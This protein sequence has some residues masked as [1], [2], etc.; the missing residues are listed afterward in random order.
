MKFKISC[1]EKDL[2]ENLVN[3]LE[4]ETLGLSHC[5]TFYPLLKKFNRGKNLDRLSL[6]NPFEIIDLETRRD[7][8]SIPNLPKAS[9]SFASLLK[10]FSVKFS[11]LSI[12]S[13]S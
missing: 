1:V 3:F 10:T 12:I 7:S 9:M 2:P 11:K 6:Q 4:S 13:I 5:Q 8:F